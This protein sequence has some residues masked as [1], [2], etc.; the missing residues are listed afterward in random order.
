MSLPTFPSGGNSIPVEVFPPVGT[1]NGGLVVIAHGS[2]GMVAPWAGMIQDYA[3]A[4]AAKQF[5]AIIPYYFGQA[6]PPLPPPALFALIPSFHKV[7][8]DAIAFGKTLPAV[9]AARVG[10]LGFSLGGNLCLRLRG[11]AKVVVSYFAPNMTLGGIGPPAATHPVF[12]QLHHGENDKISQAESIYHQLKGEHTATELHTYVEAT[13]GFGGPGDASARV[14]S[15]SL[16]LD[17]L[18]ARL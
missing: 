3:K 14:Q 10:L 6:T 11:P 8:S 4:L 7:L 18:Q 15:K 12:V 17:F 5:T 1:P 2:D 13:H 9:N 16:T